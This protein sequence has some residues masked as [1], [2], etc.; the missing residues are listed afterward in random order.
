MTGLGRQ[1][2]KVVMANGSIW[3]PACKIETIPFT[4]QAFKTPLLP[5]FLNGAKHRFSTL[6]FG[7]PL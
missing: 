5:P 4:G 2:S 6:S 1:Y 7:W 3:T